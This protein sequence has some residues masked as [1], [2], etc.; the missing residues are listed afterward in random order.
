MEMMRKLSILSVVV[1]IVSGCVSS[2]T[3]KA[4]EQESIQLKQSLDSTKGDYSDLQEKSK[5]LAEDNEAMVLKLNKLAED[6][7]ATMLKLKKLEA[8]FSEVTAGNE[9]LKSDSEQL[10]KENEKLITAAKPENLLKTLVESFSMLQAENVRL[11]QAL[12]SAEKAAQKNGPE[13]SLEHR[14]VVAKPVA[15]VDE[16]TNDK[17]KSSS[18]Q[19]KESV[20]PAKEPADRSIEKKV[21]EKQTRSPAVE[22]NL[23]EEP[24]A[25]LK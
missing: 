21:D 22:E 24:A 3:Y 4:K 18:A 15:S 17:L 25:E 13:S 7:D 9:K 20:D 1:L 2:G 12:V 8:D 16:G 6:K 5:K 11:K 10:K 14:S 23:P 19:S